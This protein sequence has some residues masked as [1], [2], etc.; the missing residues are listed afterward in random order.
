MQLFVCEFIVNE[1]KIILEDQLVL[2]QLR[3]VLRS[4]IGDNFF[5]QNNGAAKCRYEIKIE[6]WDDGK[7]MWN[8]VWNQNL[9]CGDNRT[10]MIVCMPNKWD[11]AEMIVQKLTEIGVNHIVFWPSERS[12]IR[13]INKNK[14]ERLEKISKEALEQSWWWTLPKIE[15]VYD[16][17][18]VLWSSNLIIFDKIVDNP[19]K[20]NKLEDNKHSIYWLVGPEWWLTDNDYKNF[21]TWFGIREFGESILRTETAAIIWWWEI[22]K[23][24]L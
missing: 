16:L 5:V 9:E 13:D 24:V 3:K 11:K 8:I 10:G 20:A 21:G 18:T 2:Y 4:K 14:F 12:I 23:I 7:L 22:K 15:F 19:N 17:Q 6:K 1:N